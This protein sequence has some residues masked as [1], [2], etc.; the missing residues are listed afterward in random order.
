MPSPS[1]SS[2][3][4]DV[5]KWAI[6]SS[7]NPLLFVTFPSPPLP[8]PQ[9]VKRIGDARKSIISSMDMRLF[10]VS[11]SLY[12][13]VKRGAID[14]VDHPVTVSIRIV[15]VRMG[16]IDLVPVGPAVPVRIVREVAGAEE[17]F[18]PREDAV[19]VLVLHVDQVKGIPTPELDVLEVVSALQRREFCDHIPHAVIPD[20]DRRPE[21]VVLRIGADVRVVAQ[22]D[23]RR[24]GHGRFEGYPEDVP[25][26]LAGRDTRIVRVGVRSNEIAFG[27]TQPGVVDN[28]QGIPRHDVGE[29]ETERRAV[30]IGELERSYRDK[31][32]ATVFQHLERRLK[33]EG[34]VDE[35]DGRKD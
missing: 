8:P 9:A 3:T 31:E 35:Y 4:G 21:G 14:A 2:R 10:M 25:Q 19:A 17:P 29:V 1:V 23:E 6:C 7:V 27:K 30:R 28:D 34:G 26:S 13:Q 18:L 22:A 15:R 33:V 20:L 11:S 5:P 12:V 16:D 32:G 24:A